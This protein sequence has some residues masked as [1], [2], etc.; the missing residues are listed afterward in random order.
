MLMAATIIRLIIAQRRWRRDGGRNGPA[1]QHRWKCMHVIWPMPCSFFTTSVLRC[2]AP[3]L[4]TPSGWCLIKQHL[5]YIFSSVCG[6]SGGWYSGCYPALWTCRYPLRGGA[7]NALRARPCRRFGRVHHPGKATPSPSCALLNA[8]L[9]L[10]TE[11]SRWCCW[12]II[13]IL[14]LCH[15]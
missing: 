8:I 11:L 13:Y 7:T 12:H 3:F 1:G 2:I 5:R 9:S 10:F 14:P 6:Q 15:T 4:S